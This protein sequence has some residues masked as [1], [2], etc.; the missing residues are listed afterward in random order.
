[1]NEFWLLWVYGAPLLFA[2]NLP[3]WLLIASLATV[4]IFW[5]AR[6]IAIGYWSVSTPLDV[7]LAILLALGVVAVAVSNNLLVSVPLY[8]QLFGGV[9]LFYGIV[10]GLKATQVSRAVWILLALGAGMALLGALGIRYSGKF[11]PLP[12][13]ARFLPEL[14][15]T[16]LNPRGFTAN[17]VGGAIAPLVPLAFAWGLTLAGAR[18][19]AVLALGVLLMFAVVLTQSRGALLGVVLGLGVLA[20][21][22]VPRAPIL[23][24][25]GAAIVAALILLTP[26]RAT[27]VSM[28]DDPSSTVNSRVELW[29]RALFV[30]RDFPFT[31]IGLGTFDPNA[32]LLYPLLENTPGEPQPHAH[33]IYLQMGVD[34]GVGGFVAFLALV[35]TTLGV[36]VTNARRFAGTPM[37]W[38][39]LGLLASF[40]AFLG[41]GLLD[42]VFLSTKVG[43][44]IWTI[45]A[46]MMILYGKHE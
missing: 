5:L 11:L 24:P 36:G 1:M 26:L 2:S 40:V 37:A 10:N 30:M 19:I 7:P 22:R 33:N 17:I 8:L 25:I 29:E 12:L 4:P 32:L 39:A 27:A 35:T 44:G 15:V 23:V 21:W 42:A 45:L 31:G 16:L 6:R 34:Y 9:A 14:D 43:L 38:L 13:V 46:L 41:H 3:L 20:L 18:R 28:L